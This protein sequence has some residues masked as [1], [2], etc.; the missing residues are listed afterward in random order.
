MGRPESETARA[1]E[2]VAGAR[3]T[4]EPRSRPS[5]LVPSSGTT[6]SGPGPVSRETTSDPTHGRVL[7][8]VVL[9]VSLAGLLWLPCLWGLE[10][11]GGYRVVAANHRRYL[12]GWSGMA[13]S[14]VRQYQTLSFLDA[15]LCRAGWLAGLAVL[16]LFGGRPGSRPG[17]NPWWC[18]LLAGGALLG[19]TLPVTLLAVLGLL[20]SLCGNQGRTRWGEL[21]LWLLLAWWVSLSLATP[22]YTPYPRLTL[23]WLVASWLA[24]GAW[25]G[26]WWMAMPEDH[27]DVVEDRSS[28]S[29]WQSSWAWGTWASLWLL[30]LIL[31][32]NR[33]GGWPRWIGHPQ[34]GLADGARQVVEAVRESLAISDKQPVDA[35]IYV[36]AEPALVFHLRAQGLPV[37]QPV[38]DLEFTRK[39]GVDRAP[40]FVILGDRS[41]REPGFQ[42]PP[43]GDARWRQVA[44]LELAVPPLVWLDEAWQPV[45]DGGL[46]RPDHLEV[47][48]VGAAPNP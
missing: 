44:H 14:V 40:T 28:A 7:L 10:S 48:R 24:A 39:P 38:Q 15:P 25:V 33:G 9:L 42:R 27:A 8:R 20:V 34:Q 22:G 47:W 30:T 3:N 46:D 19:G 2:G 16:A 13:A 32:G 26:G 6:R 37:V 17:R 45:A 35:L 4:T 5:H 18:V 11:V 43:A 1:I 23:P 29:L 21:P 36:H 31:G 12:V 41:Q